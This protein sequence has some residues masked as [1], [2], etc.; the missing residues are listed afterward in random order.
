MVHLFEELG[1]TVNDHQ[2]FS[3]QLMV[4]SLHDHIN[5]IVVYLL[6]NM[7]IWTAFCF[8]WI[9]FIIHILVFMIMSVF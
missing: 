7:K 5:N 6:P 4:V 2:F 3:Y 1:N 9:S 8:L